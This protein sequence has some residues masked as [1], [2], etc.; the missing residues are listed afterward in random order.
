MP[1]DVFWALANPV[2]RQILPS[3]RD[4]PQP[5]NELASRFE[6]SR[7]AVS[8]HPFERDWPARLR[9]L[10]TVLDD[11]RGP[12]TD[13]GYDGMGAGWPNLLTRVAAT[14]RDIGVAA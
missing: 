8:E 9:A 10:E 4:R 3:L 12:A 5:V 1:S 6:L 2:G 13:H 11:Q 14:L 7:P